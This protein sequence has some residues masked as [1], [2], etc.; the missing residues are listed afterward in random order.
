MPIARQAFG[1]REN[2]KGQAMK[3]W[4]EYMGAVREGAAIGATGNEN[5]GTS[6]DQGAYRTGLGEPSGTPYS[7]VLIPAYAGVSLA[8]PTLADATGQVTPQFV[9]GGGDDLFI[10]TEGTDTA[11]GGGGSDTLIGN[12]GNDFLAGDDGADYLEGGAGDDIMFSRTMDPSAFAF[13][14]YRAVSDDYG[15]EV[16]TLV[17]GAGDDY[18]VAGYGDNV[19]GGTF[20]SFGNRLYVT[21]RGASSGVSADFRLLQT[22]GSIT[23]GGGVITNIQ[24]IGFLEGS[25]FADLL[26]PID[27]YYPTG[28]NVYGRGGND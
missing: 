6:G 19:D 8:S 15:T 25:D 14:S 21:F 28:A 11:S 2:C 10:G 24:T 23:I 22:Q 13:I 20:S 26:V 18:M 27:T 12:G 7:T 9:G 5:S 17:G 3:I 16:D 1:F 4:N